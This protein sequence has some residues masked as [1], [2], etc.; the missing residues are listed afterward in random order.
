M[1]LAKVRRAT[2]GAVGQYGHLALEEREGIMV[3][4]AEGTGVGETARAT[5]RDKSTISK[6]LARNS[7]GVR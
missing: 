5:G 2:G 7:G 3:M 6:G 4:R 1:A